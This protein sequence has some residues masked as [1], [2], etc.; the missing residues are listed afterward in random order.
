MCSLLVKNTVRRMIS[1][2]QHLP[3]LSCFFLSDVVATI[4][5]INIITSA[6]LQSYTMVL[7]CGCKVT[8]CTDASNVYTEQGSL[9]CGSEDVWLVG[10]GPFRESRVVV[11][12]QK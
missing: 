2:G 5:I 4:Y 11:L 6:S 3:F 1:D 10:S 12:E 8:V 9:S 7:G